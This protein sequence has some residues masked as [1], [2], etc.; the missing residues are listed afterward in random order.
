MKYNKDVLSLVLYPLKTGNLSEEQKTLLADFFGEINEDDLVE[1]YHFSITTDKLK[2][3]AASLDKNDRQAYYDISKSILE[4]RGLFFDNLEA[5]AE[6]GMAL[7]IE[8]E[9][10]GFDFNIYDANE[11]KE[12]EYRKTLNN[13]SIVAA[14]VGFIPFIPVADFFILT[15][16]QIGMV[17][18]ISNLYGFKVEPREFIKMIS[19]TVGM[20]LVFKFTSSIINRLIPFVGWI[21]NATV[22]FAGTY[23]IGI[24]ARHYIESN[25]ELTKESVREIWNK[26]YEDGKTEFR[27]FK[28]YIFLKKDDLLVEVKKYFSKKH[29]DVSE[30]HGESGKEMSDREL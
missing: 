20:G 15:P 13:F 30:K 9:N 3:I 1:M 28:K 7:R 4:K 14:A 19:G 6:L 26:S 18:K 10:T 5:L 2:E 17:S 8:K 24:I 29:D 16:I 25:G 12:Y 23:A 11:L 22:A 27:K 21:V